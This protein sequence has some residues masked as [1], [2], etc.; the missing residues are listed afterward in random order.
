LVERAEY[1]CQKV[2]TLPEGWQTWNE[3]K[4]ANYYKNTFS[5]AKGEL[6]SQYS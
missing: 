5:Q 6:A 1:S 3:A 2:A 4:G